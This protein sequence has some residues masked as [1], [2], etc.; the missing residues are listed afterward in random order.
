MLTA[1]TTKSCEA[2]KDDIDSAA[3]PKND[4]F[5]TER[6]IDYMLQA[7]RNDQTRE[8]R[9]LYLQ[10]FDMLE[11]RKAGLCV[12]QTTT[13][14]AFAYTS[15]DNERQMPVIN[16]PAQIWN[17]KL[18]NA[19]RSTVD[20]L[21]CLVAHEILHLVYTPPVP[22]FRTGSLKQDYKRYVDGETLVW[23]L[24]VE[25]VVRPMIRDGRYVTEQGLRAENAL[26]RTGNNKEAPAWKEYVWGHLV[27]PESIWSRS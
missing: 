2:R 8:V 3:Q 7:A 24:T 4:M 19:S 21:I 17:K 14:C 22:N 27:V 23:G 11:S 13:D 26:R 18:T 9:N 10:L 20:E 12:L 16:F 5:K 1:P 6:T 25:Q 15:W